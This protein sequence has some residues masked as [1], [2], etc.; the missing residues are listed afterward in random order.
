MNHQ[1]DAPFNFS[2]A[3]DAKSVAGLSLKDRKGVYKEFF[4][5][6]WESFKAAEA[7]SALLSRDALV[8]VARLC[9]WMSDWIVFSW[10]FVVSEEPLVMRELAAESK[11]KLDYLRSGLP[12][13][14]EKAKELN[15]ILYLEDGSKAPMDP[16]EHAY[17]DKLL[18]ELTEEVVQGE[19]EMARISETLPQLESYRSKPGA[20]RKFF[21]IMA[22]GGFGRGELTY[23]SDVDIAYL[24]DPT[25][26][27]LLELSAIQELIRRLEELFVDL[28]LELASQYFELHE[29]LSR[30]SETQALHAIPSILEAKVILGNERTLR[31]FK[32]Q[33]RQAC[34]KEKLIRF[35]RTQSAELVPA[36]IDELHIKAGQGGLRHLQYVFWTLVVLL[37]PNKTTTLELADELLRRRWITRVEA[38]ILRQTLEFYLDLRNFLGLFEHYRPQLALMGEK[39]LAKEPLKIDRFNDRAAMAYLKI[40]V[41][42]TTIDQL[43]R[44]RLNSARQFSRIA[45]KVL[46]QVL[47]RSFEEKLTHFRLVKHLRSNEVQKLLSYDAAGRQRTSD[48]NLFLDW[49]ALFELFLYLAN[50]G[51]ALSSQLSEGFS[52]LLGDLYP[53]LEQIPKESLKDFIYQ[54]FRADYASAAIGQML[55][56]SLPLSSTGDAKTLL[57]LFLPEVNKMR[58]LLRNLE[59]HSYPLCEHSL[60]AIGQMEKEIVAFRSKEPELWRF[61]EDEDIFSLKWS[62]FFH[63]LGKINPYKDHEQY[64]PK[65]AGG[66]L[67]RLGFDG[68]SDQLEMIRLLVQHH[69]SMVRYSKLST[70][71]DLGILKFF[72]L[73]QRDPKRLILLYMINI[74][75]FKSVNARMHEKAG[76]LEDFFERTLAILEEFRRRGHEKTLTQTINHFLDAKVEEQKD[77]VVL[78]LLLRQSCNR[79]LDEVITEPLKALSTGEAEALDKY[80]RELSSSAHYIHLGELD[81]KSLEKHYVRFCRI[82]SDNLSRPTR[83]L[84]AEPYINNWD[85]FFATIP[86]RYLLSASPQ[87]LAHQLIDFD[88]E[89]RDD[90]RFSFVKGGP[91]EYDSLLF[92]SMHDLN[93]QAKI[94]FALNAKGINL[95]LGKINQ[96]RYAD[97]KFGIVGFFQGTSGNKANIS[98]VEL[99]SMV[100]NL[101]PPDLA[102]GAHRKAY[103]GMVQVQYMLEREKGYLVVETLDGSFQREPIECWAVKVSLTDAPYGYFKI[104]MALQALNVTPL[105]VTVTTIGNQIVDYFYVRPDDCARLKEGGFEPLL[106]HYMGSEIQAQ[107]I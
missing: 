96:V 82:L 103:A 90:L 32:A 49:E 53:K 37:E 74:S 47:D 8:D 40:K 105:Q 76:H 38:D 52:V 99:E 93:V 44:F 71:M 13:K 20:Y 31:A 35:L 80:R 19:K 15:Q 59:V 62:I 88:A 4:T 7:K 102:H 25:N 98:G 97:G 33:M 75:D 12:K 16:A 9:R 43:D 100:A 69:Q 3:F 92:Y 51:N 36:R 57:G 73:A 68:N 72:E 48:L 23:S 5:E 79:S 29:D 65:L 1:P 81:E 14:S 106:S 46:Y 54:L 21:C 55:E 78:D 30:F 56:I 83:F 26:R 70:H 45:E 89:E 10:D 22:R 2:A 85:W 34:P 77:A 27:N 24:V 63:D 64:G 91:G 28:P 101:Q 18:I 67:V 17:Y 94:A 84:L 11:S 60:K 86:N 6:Q 39:D 50:N 41:R 66:M 58:Y 42:F 104:M 95:E 107:G 61:L 87:R